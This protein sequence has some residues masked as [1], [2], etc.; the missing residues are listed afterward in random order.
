MVGRKRYGYA[1]FEF[2][3][4]FNLCPVKKFFSDDDDWVRD[5][6]FN[7]AVRS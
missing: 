5:N 4:P 6:G 3:I 2:R 7:Y 1:P